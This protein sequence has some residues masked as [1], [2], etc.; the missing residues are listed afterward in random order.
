MDCLC[1]AECGKVRVMSL[2]EKDRTDDAKRVLT[3]MMNEIGNNQFNEPIVDADKRAYKSAHD[4]TWTELLNR[5][6]IDDLGW[7]QYRLTKYGWLK[8]VELLGLTK[9]SQFAGKMSKLSATLRGYVT[10]RPDHDVMVD[11]FKVEQDSGLDHGFVYNALASQLLDQEYGREGSAYFD[12]ADQNEHIII[13][14]NNYG[15]RFLKF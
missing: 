1:S 14:P 13:I 6:Y 2:S 15:L 5:L 7:R 11:I 9:D 3:L 4:T 10:S 8:G 12:P